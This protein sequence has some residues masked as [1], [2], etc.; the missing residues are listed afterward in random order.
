MEQCNNLTIL[1]ILVP[2]LL[3]TEGDCAEFEDKLYY[4][5]KDDGK[6]ANG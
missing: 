3:T 6:S 4:L 1:Q 2:H 5:E